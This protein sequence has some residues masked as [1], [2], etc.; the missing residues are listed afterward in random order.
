M[1]MN[2]QRSVETKSYDDL[3]EECKYQVDGQCTVHLRRE[4]MNVQWQKNNGTGHWK[5]SSQ[6]INNGALYEVST[7]HAD[8]TSCV[9]RI[10][11]IV[12]SPAGPSF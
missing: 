5:H 9:G 8:L 4:V 7:D 10:D 6:R 3:N 12:S 11:S 2:K 1:K